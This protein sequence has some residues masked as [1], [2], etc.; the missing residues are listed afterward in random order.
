MLALTDAAAAAISAL[1]ESAEF[2]HGGLRIASAAAPAEGAVE[3]AIVD[4]PNEG[5]RIV[6][7]QGASVFVDPALEDQLGDTVLDAVLDE[8]GVH[9]GLVDHDHAG[10]HHH[11]S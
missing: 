6:V 2:E 4:G 1:A 8:D 10:E 3:L 9:F 7:V 5:D 11:H